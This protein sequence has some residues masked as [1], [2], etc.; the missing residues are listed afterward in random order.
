[1]PQAKP[2]V[3]PTRPTAQRPKPASVLILGSG[4]VVIGQ[5]AEFDYA[6]TQACRALRA[7]GIRTILVNSNPATIMTDPDV[8]DAVYL[9]PLTVE[10]V[11]AVIAKERPEGLLAGL[12]GQTALNL[13]VALSRAGVLD[14]HGV[15][16]LGTPLSAIEMAED[17]EAFRD[18]LDRIDQP[19]APSAIVVGEDATERDASAAMAL[20]T[21][22]LPAI[23]RPAFTLGGTGGGIVE[24]A[25]AYWERVR[26]GLRASPIRQVMVERCLV[27]WQEIEYEVVRDAD[28]TCIAVCSMEN[29]DPL[30]VHTGDSIVVA[31]VQTLTDAV[32]QRLRSAALAII[33]ALGVEGGCNV[34]FALSPDASEY[35]VIEVNPRVSRSSA[36]ASKAT[37]Y[38]IARVAAQIAAGRR[39]AEIPNVVTGTTVAAFEPAL[40]YVVV[41]LPRFPFDKF[42]TADR[43]LGSQMKATGEVMA[44]DRTFG[45]ALN[46]ALRGLEQAGAGPLAEDPGW[47]ATVAYLAAVYGT[48]RDGGA[49]GDPPAGLDTLP[50]PGEPPDPGQPITWV[51]EHGERCESTRHAERSAAPVVLRRF[52]AP[53]DSRLWRILGLMRRGVPQAVIGEV[54]GIS[55]WFLAELGRNV[56]LEAGARS[57]GARLADP[58]DAEAMALLSTAKRLAFSDRE[59]SQLSGVPA[60][61]VARARAAVGLVP[62]YAMVDTCAAEFAAE[63]PYFYST[64]AAAGSMPEAPPVARPAALVIGSGPVRIGQGIEFDYC[65]VR[66][67]DTLRR[68]GWSAVMVNSNPE[69]VSTD[70]DASTRLYFEPLDFESVRAVVAAET[71]DGQDLLPAVVAFGGQTPLNLA[72]SLAADGVPLLGADLEAIDQ[73]EERTRFATLLDRLGIPQPEGGMAR[74]VDEALALA[75]R[76]GYPVIV[77]PSFVIGGLAIDFAYSPEDLARQLAAATVVDPDRPVRIDRYLEGVEVDVDAVADGEALLIPGLLEHVERAGVHSGDSVGVFPP[78]S[79]SAWD[80]ELIVAAMERVVMALGARGLVNAQFIVRDDGV[81]LI[82]VNPRASR[83]VPFLSKVTGVPMV[84]LAVRIALGSTLREQGWDGGLLP[85]PGFVAVKAPAFS[86]SKLRGV[87]PSV[88]PG[89][90]STGEVIGIHTD[91]RVATAKALL[92]ASLTPPRPDERGDIALLSIAD[93]D[94][95]LLLRLGRALVAAGYRLAATPGT[96]DMLAGGGIDA[97][98]VAKLGAPP[99]AAGVPILE[100]IGEGSVRL[101]VNTPTPRSGAVRDAA[102]IRHAAVAEGILCLTAS[103]TA[104]AAAE[105]LDP[106]IL[107]R[108]AEVRSLQDWVPDAR[109]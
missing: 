28:D 31:P 109:C 66:A 106:A 32:H 50:L 53:S 16:L 24:T 107:L 84:D 88:G 87:D 64:Y 104:V 51:D 98:L 23:V 38:P 19:Y 57:L 61:A 69:T 102:D 34:Q 97:L 1:M 105:A 46:K 72:A 41:K 27:G 67:A 39:L 80:Q 90:Q 17:R 52:L 89:M 82:E 2:A 63:T 8:A 15:R 78:Q 18:L 91:P 94:K 4:P 10:A 20:D 43:T 22:G 25:E 14:R 83:T 85:P 26:A 48:G 36:L 81:Y 76:I 3:S 37:G 101:V 44:I 99:E 30:G 86:T 47:A 42:P 13:T 33:R 11:E 55:P 12:G 6:G 96:R 45:A 71:P 68:E 103:E 77:R 95:G 73:A 5:A 59:L 100:L 62:G 74:S 75:D 65:A 49:P 60:A 108:L 54:T 7:E 79:V 92:G 93:R 35:A 40:D 58:A 56:S 29:V 21:I 9:E 70:F